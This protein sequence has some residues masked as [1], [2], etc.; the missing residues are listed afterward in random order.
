MK[1][2]Y[3]IL[4]ARQQRVGRALSDC[5]A[6]AVWPHGT[7]I[8]HHGELILLAL[9]S[10]T[11]CCETVSSITALWHVVV[12][13]V[14]LKAA[15]GDMV[16]VGGRGGVGDGYVRGSGAVEVAA[17][18]EVNGRLGQLL[19][20]VPTDGHTSITVIGQTNLNGFGILIAIVSFIGESGGG[21]CQD[22]GS[23]EREQHGGRLG[24]MK[25]RTRES[26]YGKKC[27]RN[28]TVTSF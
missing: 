17:G 1:R 19:F 11:R 13:G 23:F 4:L 21:Q 5:R 25:T 27:P 24:S 16:I 2:L 18:A 3:R 20:R 7:K 12:S 22:G 6:E 26:T 10:R 9:A 28:W 15:D 14:R 8:A